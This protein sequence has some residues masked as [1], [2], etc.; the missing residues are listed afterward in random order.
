M[1]L[2]NDYLKEVF[3]GKKLYVD[4]ELQGK[5]V[6]AGI[7]AGSFYYQLDNRDELLTVTFPELI[8][9]RDD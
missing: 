6:D 5:I 8:E 4:G 9:I 7:D 3:A 1:L 2:I